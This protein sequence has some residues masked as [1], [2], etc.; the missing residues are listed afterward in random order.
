MTNTILTLLSP[1]RLKQHYQSGFWQSETIYML[2]R[3]HAELAPDRFALRDRYRRL[4][5]KQTIEAAHRLAM[6][7]AA[8]GVRRGQRVAVWLSS[9][10]VILTQ[11]D[12]QAAVPDPVVRVA[13]EL[14]Q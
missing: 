8:K 1:E 2:A 5:F 11:E 9:R 3:G 14:K 13:P 6:D 10:R 7:L 4:T 12:G